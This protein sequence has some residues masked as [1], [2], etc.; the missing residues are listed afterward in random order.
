VQKLYFGDDFLLRRLDY[1]TDVVGGVAAHYCYDLVTIDGI[2]FPTLR[3]VVGTPEGSLLSGRT[4]FILDY[5]DLA[6]RK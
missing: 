5:T 4:S 6:V 3:R 1:T 2:V